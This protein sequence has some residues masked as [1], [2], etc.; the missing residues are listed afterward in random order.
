MT[1][2]TE[3]KINDPMACNNCFFFQPF[4]NNPGLGECHVV[5]PVVWIHNTRTGRETNEPVPSRM[6]TF[7]I[8]IGTSFCGEFQEKK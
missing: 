6:G 3:R 7:P 1:P 8:M 4:Q 2:V 5:P